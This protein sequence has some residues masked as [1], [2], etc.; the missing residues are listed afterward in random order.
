MSR[1]SHPL[2]RPAALVFALALLPACTTKA[3][4]RR[5]GAAHDCVSETPIPASRVLSASRRGPRLDLK[6]FYPLGPD[7][8]SGRHDLGRGTIQLWSVD[9][10]QPPGRVSAHPWT[11]SG[12]RRETTSVSVLQE[13]PPATGR[14]RDETWILAAPASSEAGVRGFLVGSRE[15]RWT[16]EVPPLPGDRWALSGTAHF[17]LVMVVPLAFVWDIVTFPIQVLFD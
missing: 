7:R 14:R 12:G 4:F 17:G 10:A 1:P 15:G 6:V 5:L 3:V 9:L 2:R 8:P 13:P 11:S 16:V